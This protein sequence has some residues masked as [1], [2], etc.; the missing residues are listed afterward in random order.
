[1]D[2]L[3]R[4]IGWSFPVVWVAWVVYWLARAWGNKRTATRSNLGWRVTVLVGIGLAVAVHR[5]GPN[6]MDRPLYP[7]N[8]ARTEIGLALTVLGLGLTV[9]ARRML[10]T[11]WSANPSIKVDHELITSGPYALVRHPIYTGLLLAIFGSFLP[12]SR[13][14][15]ILSFAI[16]VVLLVIKLRIEEGLMRR[17]FPDT[18][19][20]YCRQTRALV[21]FVF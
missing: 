9:W 5:L 4:A 2:A 11:N 8:W 12:A 7:P 19:P 16:A 21:P 13:F 20:D 3:H 14:S 10:G 18:Y 15:D 1:M 6:W 17:Q